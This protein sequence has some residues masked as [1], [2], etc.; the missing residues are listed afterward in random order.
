MSARPGRVVAEIA[1]DAAVAARAA[2]SATSPR[3]PVARLRRER[4]RRRSERRRH[5][6]RR[7][8]RWLPAARR[9]LGAARSAGRRW[10]AWR[11]IPHYTLPAPSL[12]AQT[13]WRELPSLASSWWFTLQDHLRRAAARRL[14]GVAARRAVRAVAPGR[15]GAVPVR[16]RA[17]GDPDRRDRAADPD[18]RRQHHR[19]A[20]DVRVDRRVLPDPVE[21]RDRPARRRPEPARPVPP[22]PARRR[23]QRLRLLLVPSALP[24]FIAGL[25]ISGG[26]SLIGA[27]IAEFAAG[28]AGRETGPRLAHPGG[29]LPHRDAEDVRGAALLVADRRA[30]FW[31]ST[32][33]RRALL[34]RW[35]ASRAATDQPESRDRRRR[36]AGSPPVALARPGAV[37]GADRAEAQPT[38]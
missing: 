28:A 31:R 26:L 4:A 11:S 15:D 37:A 33:C 34:G 9:S 14:G 21:H 27:V 1:I 10:C 18:L 3:V 38:R 32:R 22:V 29:E 20:A 23:W 19:G 25:K 6:S 13:L 17:A 2:P 7:A 16:D 8:A 24:Y 12:V 35:H 5:E 36:S 30:I